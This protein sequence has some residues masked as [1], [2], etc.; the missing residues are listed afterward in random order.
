M[1]VNY[2]TGFA[3]IIEPV[4]FGNVFA[5]LPNEYDRTTIDVETNEA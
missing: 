5:I 1:E 4:N 3:A 2:D